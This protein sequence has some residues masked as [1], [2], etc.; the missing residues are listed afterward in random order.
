[1]ELQNSFAVF[2]IFF[3]NNESGYLTYFPEWEKL[4][5]HLS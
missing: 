1:M 5:L 3:L 4:Q 2:I